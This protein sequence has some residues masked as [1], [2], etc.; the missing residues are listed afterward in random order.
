M[1]LHF[2]FHAFPCNVNSTLIKNGSETAPFVSTVLSGE[3]MGLAM[4]NAPAL[5]EER[6]GAVD[7]LNL[8]KQ[9]IAIG[10][11]YMDTVKNKDQYEPDLSIER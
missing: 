1:W 8:S 7:M 9:E 5:Q 11:V 3:S 10:S 2:A 4:H 6:A